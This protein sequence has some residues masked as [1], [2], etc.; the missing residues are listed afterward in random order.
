MTTNIYRIKFSIPITSARGGPLYVSG[1]ALNATSKWDLG[2]LLKLQST[3]RQ[4][5]TEFQPTSPEVWDGK[6]WISVDRIPTV[7]FATDKIQMRFRIDGATAPLNH[8]QIRWLMQENFE[9][10][11][12]RAGMRTRTFVEIIPSQK[13][14]QRFVDGVL[15]VE[16]ESLKASQPITNATRNGYTI[17]DSGYRAFIHAEFVDRNLNVAALP[18]RLTPNGWRSLFRLNPPLPA[19]TTVRDCRALFSKHDQ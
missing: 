2:E 11:G 1:I 12:V 4:V 7:D 18:S 16:F 10:E 19:P 17:S 9:K 3:F 15:F 5:R 14:R 6:S 13:L 8:I